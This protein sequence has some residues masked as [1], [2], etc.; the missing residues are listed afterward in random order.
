MET[1]FGQKYHLNPENLR[2]EKNRI[3]RKKKLII[4]ALSAIFIIT[5]AIGMRILYDQNAKS[6]RLIN[7]EKQNQELRDEYIELAQELAKDESILAEFQNKDDRLYRSIIGMDPLPASIREAGTGGAVMHPSLQTIS[8]PEMVINVFEKIDKVLNKAKIQY[9][10]FDDLEAAAFEKQKLLASKPSIQPVSPSDR[11]W[12]TS[13][14]GYRKD[15]FTKSR[16]FHRGIDLAGQYGLKI[17]ATG[18]GVVEIAEYN[19]YGYG[20]EVVIDHGFGFESKYAHLQKIMVKPG[21]KV[22]R[23]QVIGTLGSSGR[24]TGPHLHYEICLNN[25]VINPMFYYF[26]DLTP[27]EYSMISQLATSN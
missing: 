24:S 7:Y 4:T 6:P 16:R 22:K 5:T 26:E 17:H 18:D 3:P 20:K 14:F 23:G 27:E 1:I 2:F 21:Q 19:H 8:N 11:Y 12:L 10:S 9:N 15:P 13:T 25:K